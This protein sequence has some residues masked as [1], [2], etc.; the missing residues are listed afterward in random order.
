MFEILTCL[1]YRQIPLCINGFK[2][3]E[4]RVYN[5][6]LAGTLAGMQDE[7]PFAQ[8]VIDLLLLLR[9]MVRNDPP[10]TN[11][12]QARLR[13][14]VVA[15]TQYLRTPEPMDQGQEL[16]GLMRVMRRSAEW[17]VRA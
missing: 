3:P 11:A 16:H 10:M 17:P 8:D 13:S 12:I 6:L 1:H 5:I 15:R 7:S 14:E 4:E 9:A 2:G